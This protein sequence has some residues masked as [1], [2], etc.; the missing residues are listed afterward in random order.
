[1]SLASQDRLSQLGL[2]FASGIAER[3]VV[4]DVM[5]DLEEALPD[6]DWSDQVLASTTRDLYTT[7]LRLDTEDRDG[8]WWNLIT[9]AMAPVFEGRFDYLVGN[10]PWVSWETLPNEYRRANETQWDLYSLRPDPP[11]G[12]R[13]VSTSVPLD[14]SMLF[15]A[16]CM[17]RYLAEGGRL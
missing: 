4:N 16:H 12:Q 7:L 5:T 11:A 3:A 9:N 8:L 15:V 17:D 6:V 2:V 10:P 1:R 14:L 13:Q